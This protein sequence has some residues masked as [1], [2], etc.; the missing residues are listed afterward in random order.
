MESLIRGMTGSDPDVQKNS[1]EAVSLLLQVYYSP[2][3]L[4]IDY[5]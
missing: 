1:V 2:L 3:W 4:I 5:S